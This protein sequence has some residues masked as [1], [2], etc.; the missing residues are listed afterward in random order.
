MNRDKLGNPSRGEP[1]HDES[2]PRRDVAFG[3]FPSV[4]V[5]MTLFSRAAIHFCEEILN[6]V[7]TQVKRIHTQCL[8]FF[9]PLF[10]S[11]LGPS[12]CNM[13]TKFQVTLKQVRDVSLKK[14]H[15]I[16]DVIPPSFNPLLAR[17]VIPIRVSPLCKLRGK[18]FDPRGIA[19]YFNLVIWFFFSSAQSDKVNP[20]SD[21]K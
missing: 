9:S 8:S 15:A 19:R 17:I 18:S 20:G 21:S 6:E 4:F 16:F 14:T 2:S 1:P 12:F 10:P 3:A 7:K 5:K 11:L 13:R